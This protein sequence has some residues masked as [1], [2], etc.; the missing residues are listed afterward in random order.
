MGELWDASRPSL[1][2]PPQN[3][4]CDDHD[5][6]EKRPRLFMSNGAPYPETVR[7]RSP[8]K[9]R[10]PLDARSGS[11]TPSGRCPPSGGR[12]FDPSHTIAPARALTMHARRAVLL[13]VGLCGMA[14]WK[15][16]AHGHTCLGQEAS[17]PNE[18][19]RRPETHIMDVCVKETRMQVADPPMRP[20]R[21]Q[22]S[23]TSD[24]TF[25]AMTIQHLVPQRP[26]ARQDASQMLTRSCLRWHRSLPPPRQPNRRRL[27]E[28]DIRTG[29]CKERLCL[30][31]AISR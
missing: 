14:P 15:R 22:L 29:G 18:S 5:T 2:R 6:D 8:R 9:R 27:H 20:S 31:S 24:G 21:P 13:G 26:I 17:S 12:G 30:R 19:C 11:A 28:A 23:P 10:T 16:G 4:P 25:A 7:T 3:A 1:R